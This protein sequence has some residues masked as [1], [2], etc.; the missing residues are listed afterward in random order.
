MT[1]AKKADELING[2]YP[3]TDV[4]KYDNAIKCAIIAVDEIISEHQIFMYQEEH[5]IIYWTEVLTEL[6]LRK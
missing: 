1:P 5:R 3:Q 2:M 6:K 4:P